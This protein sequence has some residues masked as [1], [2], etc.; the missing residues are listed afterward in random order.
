M[1]KIFQNKTSRGGY[2]RVIFLNLIKHDTIAMFTYNIAILVIGYNHEEATRKF[3]RVFYRINIW[4]K[5]GVYV[6]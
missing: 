5:D 2:I 1:K 6:E 4:T 3:Q